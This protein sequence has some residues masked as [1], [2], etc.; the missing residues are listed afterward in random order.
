MRVAVR[1]AAFVA[2][3]TAPEPVPERVRCAGT[4]T[5]RADRGAGTAVRARRDRDGAATC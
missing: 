1:A 4:A 5:T 3:L 2:P